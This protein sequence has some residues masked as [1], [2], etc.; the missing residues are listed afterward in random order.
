M[1]TV[2]E[3]GTGDPTAS[4]DT[5]TRNRWWPLSPRRVLAVAA[6]LVALQLVVRGIVAFAGDFY[7]DDLILVSRSGQ[8]SV[9]SGAFLFYDHDGHFMPAAF[10]A[11]WLATAV[12]PLNWTVPAIMLIVLQ[13]AASLAVLRV[14]RLLLGTRAVLLLPL[15]FYLFSPLTLPSFAWWAAGLNSLPMQIGLA[16]VAGDAIRLC[17]TGRTRFAVSGAIVAALSLAFFEKSVLVPIVAFAVVVLMYRVDD[18]DHPVRT[19]LAKGR[20]LWIPLAAVVAC[21]AASYLVFTESRFVLPSATQTAGL[22]HHGTSLGVI[23]TLLG[24]PWAWDRW[25]PSPPWATPPLVLVVFGWFAVAAAL[26]WSLRYRLRTG[27]VWI[28]M[29]AYVAASEAA[30]VLTRSGPDTA[31]ELAQTLR[32]VADSAVVLAIGWALIVHAPR[33]ESV[34]SLPKV[35]PV[36]VAALTMLFV[37]SSLWSTVTF[38]QRWRDNPTVDYLAHARQSLAANPDTPLLDQPVSIWVLLPVAYPHNTTSHLFAPLRDRPEFARHT[39]YLQLLDDSGRLIPAA[40]TPTRN[41][42]QGPEPG[43]GYRVEGGGAVLPLDG[44]LID[45][46]WTAQLNYF[47]SADGVVEVGLDRS[48]DTVTVPVEAGLNQVFVR[49]YGA[50]E[51]LRLTPETPGLELCVGAGPVGSVVGAPKAG[52]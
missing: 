51:G 38:V 24:G 20:A 4:S 21:W 36:A 46:E 11:A 18:I 16:W 22:L 10:L 2:P 31:Y 12:A 49:L 50:G 9:P 27:G 15:T 30:M 23:P 29:V 28:A 25:P 42:G 14:L 44:P 17:R 37:A 34:R 6:A 40:V 26:A 48:D 3:A 1:R 8:Y 5:P 43:C 33:R 35:P 47:A 7:W 19:A 13:A 39:D 52:S 41:L 32:Y 45:W